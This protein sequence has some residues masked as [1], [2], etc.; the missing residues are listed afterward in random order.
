L[1][2]NAAGAK[3]AV[4][5]LL[6]HGHTRIAFVGDD[7]RLYTAGERL[8]GYGRALSDAG[9]EMDRELVSVGNSTLEAAKRAV[10][11]LMSRAR[12]QRP[13]AIFCGNNRCTVGALHALG[14]RRR[15]IALVGFDD[16]E[17]ADLLGVTV[18]RTDPYRI[19]R[20]A[21]ELAFG[22]IDGDD[23]RPQRIVVPAVLVSRGTG[24]LRP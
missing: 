16:F 19:G 5:H 3:R 18:V 9:L 1:I 17:L 10:N 15:R 24:E 21:A 2:D 23:R 22:R 12:Q 8:A 20:E 14:A 13:T 4:A 7:L 11:E 6:A